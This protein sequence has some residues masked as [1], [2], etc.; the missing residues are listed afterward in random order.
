MFSC[1]LN[2][3][4]ALPY[5]RKGQGGKP[6]CVARIKLFWYSRRKRAKGGYCQLAETRNLWH[7]DGMRNQH[8]CSQRQRLSLSMGNYQPR[9]LVVFPFFAQLRA[10]VEERA[11]RNAGSS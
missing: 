7:T 3:C 8:H 6:G 5:S 10:P 4:A 9:C 1:S 2:G 11:A